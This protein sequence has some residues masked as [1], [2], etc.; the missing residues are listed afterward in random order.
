MNVA[1]YCASS[2]TIAPKYYEA[3]RLMGRLMAQNG[4]YKNLHDMQ[5]I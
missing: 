3:A 4:Y 5:M 1:F 2:A